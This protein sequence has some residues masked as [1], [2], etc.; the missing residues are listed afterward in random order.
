MIN[1]LR[2]LLFSLEQQTVHSSV[3]NVSVRVRRGSVQYQQCRRVWTPPVLLLL[4]GSVT[5]PFRN[6]SPINHSSLHSVNCTAGTS[7]QEFKDRQEHRMRIN[8]IIF[9]T[10]LRNDHVHG[11]NPHHRPQVLL[12]TE[13]LTF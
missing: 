4:R 13:L 6:I 2:P 3:H 9:L 8:W 10:R 11:L 5:A 12:R 1:L 7:N